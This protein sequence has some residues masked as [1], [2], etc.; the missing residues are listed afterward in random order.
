M[1][2][3][4]F[5]QKKNQKKKKKKKKKTKKNKKK[6]KKKK[7]KPKQNKTNKQT[8]FFIFIYLASK[9][10]SSSSLSLIIERAKFKNNNVLA[11]KFV[12]TMA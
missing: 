10:R 9:L 3:L 6:K 1:N 11:K 5:A 7:K 12:N 8:N 4:S 2:S